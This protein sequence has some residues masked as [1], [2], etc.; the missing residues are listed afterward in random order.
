MNG[1]GTS[2]SRELGNELD[3]VVATERA[4]QSL[5]LLVRQKG[6][7]GGPFPLMPISTFNTDYPVTG[8]QSDW[9]LPDPGRTSSGNRLPRRLL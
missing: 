4:T 3:D 2:R 7:K 8:L 5:K 9:S 6:I 1:P